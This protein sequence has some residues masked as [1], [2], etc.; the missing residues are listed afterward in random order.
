[1]KEKQGKYVTYNHA[2]ARLRYHVIFSTKF[3]RRCLDAIRNE[4]IA[5][6]REAE[7]HSHF[8]IH[9]ME[10]DSDHIHFLLEFPPKYSIE[11]TVRRLKMY[12]TKYLYEHCGEYLQKFF[13]KGKRILWTHG[14]FCSTIGEVSEGKIVDYI[15]KQG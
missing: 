2:K 13:W 15:D 3:R 10:L 1:M 6:F 14:Y 9:K 12:S 4:V 5:S 8:R 7:R 11:Q